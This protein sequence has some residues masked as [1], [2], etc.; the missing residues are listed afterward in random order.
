MKRLS[1]ILKTELYQLSQDRRVFLALC[2]YLLILLYSTVYFIMFPAYRMRGFERIN[3]LLVIFN[4]LSFSF[5]S[6]VASDI[7]TG[8][9]E[10][11]TIEALLATYCPR[12]HIYW[13]KYIIVQIFALIPIICGFILLFILK[14]IW[15]N[16]QLLYKDIF[17]V[18]AVLLPFSFLL[19]S[20]LVYK[21]FKA[22]TMRGS[23]SMDLL[24]FL[25]IPLVSLVFMFI[26]GFWS[27]ICYLCV[28]CV[29]FYRLA[30][31]GIKYMYCEDI[32]M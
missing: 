28:V 22:R 17:M 32:L 18:I 4:V 23:K 19:S 27:Y 5:A 6:L 11:K 20:I 10:R 15:V 30:K 7:T 1:T 14:A 2:I 9:K 13:A 31:Q 16:R 12:T 21:G 25:C 29:L 26:T 24:L 3:I 8:E